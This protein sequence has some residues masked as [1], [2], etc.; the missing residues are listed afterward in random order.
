MEIFLWT[1]GSILFWLFIGGLHLYCIGKFMD[2]DTLCELY[3]VYRTGKEESFRL[4]VF[5]SGVF[6]VIPPLFLFCLGKTDGFLV[7]LFPDRER[8]W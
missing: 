8:K 5:F 7:K 6:G 1:L 2:E 3:E 4:K